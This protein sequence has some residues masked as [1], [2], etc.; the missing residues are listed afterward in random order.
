[1]ASAVPR[2]R[3]A[4]AG[5]GN[6]D[7]RPVVAN[8]DPDYDDK[9]DLAVHTPDGY[10]AIDFAADGFGTWNTYPFYSAAWGSG[11]AKLVPGHYTS[12]G[13]N[14]DQ[15]I[16]SSNGYW[17]IDRASNGYGNWD[18]TF[19]TDSAARGYEAGVHRLSCTSRVPG[20]RRSDDGQLFRG[21]G[22]AERAQDR[23]ALHRQ[24]PPEPGTECMAS[25]DE[26]GDSFPNDG[27]PQVGFGEIKCSDTIDNDADG[28]VNDGCPASFESE[29]TP[30]EASVRVNPDLRVPAAL[31]VEDVGGHTVQ[32]TSLPIVYPHSR[33]FGFTCSQWGSFPLGF[34][35]SGVHTATAL[36]ADYGTGVTCT[37]DYPGLYGWVKNKRTGAAIPDASVTVDGVPVPIDV[38]G[39]W[40]LTTATGGP[41]RILV[42]RSGFAPVEAVNVRVPPFGLPAGIQ[43]DAALEEAFLLQSGISYKTYIDYSRGHTILHTIAIDVTMAPITL[44]KVP[45]QGT[46]F[47]PLL[48]VAIAQGAPVLT[49]GIWW[50]NAFPSK[51]GV[52]IIGQ[53]ECVEEVGPGVLADAID[54]LSLHQRLRRTGYV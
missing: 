24:R 15:G 29:S 22:L 16:K 21:R 42:T 4:A 1:M 40:K 43:V 20:C 51:N 8:Y 17:H 14:L 11:V 46:E 35:V 31:N 52:K 26:D 9:A 33:R 28:F 37:A 19:G 13:G 7:H 3:R 25:L 2:L 39:L 49:N 12:T 5:Y 32:G 48:D 41:H 45:Q 44:G 10:W 54:R 38:N 18:G 6:A 36:N 53:N 50:T 27:C 30:D 23:R 47:Q 34:M